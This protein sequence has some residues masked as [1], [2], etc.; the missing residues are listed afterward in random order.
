[1]I[2]E[3]ETE[4]SCQSLEE[5]KAEFRLETKRLDCF[6]VQLARFLSTSFSF[7]H[8][9]INKPGHRG[10]QGTWSSPR[11]SFLLFSRSLALLPPL[12]TVSSLRCPVGWRVGIW[13]EAS[14]G[15]GAPPRAEDMGGGFL[16]L[17]WH[18]PAG[19]LSLFAL[20]DNLHPVLLVN[21]NS[22]LG[23]RPAPTARYPRLSPGKRRRQHGLC[24]LSPGCPAKLPELRG[25]FA[26][27]P[28]LPARCCPRPHR[29][30]QF[31]L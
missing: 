23:T 26:S 9:Q 28:Q 24:P 21:Y 2:S 6:L 7:A 11:A 22:T 17:G 3:N 29:D 4:R 10:A 25:H 27:S 13:G 8:G 5:D 12:F 14:P 30:R 15:A 31:P 20:P 18:S 16:E 19:L 1:M